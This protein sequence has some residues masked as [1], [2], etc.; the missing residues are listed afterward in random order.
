MRTSRNSITSKTKARRGGMNTSKKVLLA[1]FSLAMVPISGD[2]WARYTYRPAV[3]RPAVY[4]PIIRPVYRPVYRPIIRPVYRPVYR[5]IIRPAYRPVV[6]RP[7]VSR[8]VYR[9]VK[10]ITQRP[11][12]H[13]SVHRTVTRSVSRP[14]AGKTAAQK[15]IANNPA[16]RSGSATRAPCRG[17][18]TYY[19]RGE[20]PDGM[21]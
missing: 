6:R 4:R 11:L 17:G 3:I 7:V 21:R 16:V 1:A 15:Q 9:S 10:P 8:P 18:Q 20:C 2:S 5:P 14:A 13:K 12:R 19:Y